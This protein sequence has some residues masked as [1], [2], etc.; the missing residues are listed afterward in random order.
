M[1]FVINLTNA[2]SL[3]MVAFTVVV[4]GCI[5]ASVIAYFTFRS[6]HEKLKLNHET[7]IVKIE[8]NHREIMAKIKSN[9]P[10]MIEAQPANYDNA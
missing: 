9:D 1:E 3:P 2:M 4:L 7:D 6:A 10:K 8:T 5:P